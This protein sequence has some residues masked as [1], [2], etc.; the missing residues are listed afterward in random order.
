MRKI[1]KR[2]QKEN[3]L[4]NIKKSQKKINRIICEERKC[5]RLKRKKMNATT[6]A[7]GLTIK[8]SGHQE[9]EA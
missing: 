2:I 1:T 4:K 5:I 3:K 8:Q 7:I 9:V 6:E